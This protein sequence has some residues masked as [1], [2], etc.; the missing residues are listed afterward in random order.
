L[1]GLVVGLVGLVVGLVGL[2]VGLVG[3]AVGSADLVMGSVGSVGSVVASLGF[4]VG[5][6]RGRL[7]AAGVTEPTAPGRADARRRARG[8]GLA[9]ATSG[10]SS[11]GAV[12]G[13]GTVP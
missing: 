11:G 6:R 4:V 10:D 8:F 5:L 7:G 12:A 13:S 1:V 9:A 2:V 3:F